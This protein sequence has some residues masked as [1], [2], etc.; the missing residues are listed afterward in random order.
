[1]VVIGAV[2][3]IGLVDVMDVVYVVGVVFRIFAD[4]VWFACK[5]EGIYS[6]GVKLSIGEV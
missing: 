3:V 4:S 5:V 2:D 6:R 1:M